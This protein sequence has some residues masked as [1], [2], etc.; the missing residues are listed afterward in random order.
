MPLPADWSTGPEGALIPDDGTA[1]DKIA[2]VYDKGEAPPTITITDVSGSV[3]TVHANGIAVAIV[4]CADGPRLT[5][6]DVLLVERFVSR[7][8]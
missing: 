4:A 5:V 8:A 3:Q 6:D 1:E 7:P 2:V